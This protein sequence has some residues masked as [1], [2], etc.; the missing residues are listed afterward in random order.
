MS[1]DAGL[2]GKKI[3]F[4]GSHFMSLFRGFV[5][6]VFCAVF[7]SGCGGI[8][9]YQQKKPLPP[10]SVCRIAVLPFVSESD[11]PMAGMIA[12]KVF[13]AEFQ[14]AGNYLLVQEGDILKIYQQLGVLPGQAPTL[15]QMQILASRLEAEL[16]IT[17]NVMEMRENSSGQGGVNPMLALEVQIRDGR[18]GDS[19]WRTYHRRQG[20]DYQK[21]MHF[22]TISTITGLGQ[23]VSRE[24]INLWLKEGLTQCD[25]SPQF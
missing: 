13:A 23:Q 5:V 17:G 16:L 25:V 22:G 19:L 24:I 10:G 18:T 8:R 9:P 3:C 4:C 15:E 11:Y 21:V 6:L 1:S 2:A 7:F 20:L 14:A 12:Y